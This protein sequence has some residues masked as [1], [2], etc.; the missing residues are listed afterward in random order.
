VAVLKNGDS[1]DGC[2]MKNGTMMMI[3]RAQIMV[4]ESSTTCPVSHTQLGGI[5]R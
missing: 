3:S 2:R 4:R 1:A 5:L